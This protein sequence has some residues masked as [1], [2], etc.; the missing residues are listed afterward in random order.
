MGGILVL[1]SVRPL[2]VAGVPVL[3][4]AALCLVMVAVVLAAGCVGGDII[5]EQDLVVIKLNHNGTTAWMKT[6]DS[7]KD[8]EV[9]AVIQT[10]DGGY[11]IA[12]GYSTPL[13]NQWTHFPT[14]PKIIRLSGEGDIVW[15]REYSHESRQVHNVPNFMSGIIQSPDNGFFALSRYGTIMQI[16]SSGSIIQ[17]RLHNAGDINNTQI[18]STARTDDGGMAIAGFTMKCLSNKRPECAPDDTSYRAFVEKLDPVGNITWSHSYSEQGFIQA[19]SIIELI[20]DRSFLTTMLKQNSN[21]YSN[22]YVFLNSNG[23]VRNISSGSSIMPGYQIQ[24]IPE[25]FSVF[26]VNPNLNNTLIEYS[27]TNEGFLINTKNLMNISHH[28]T[29]PDQ[30][31][32]IITR[33][34]NY[35]ST[36]LVESG[37]GTK[38]PT[39]TVNLK[40]LNQDG[41][42]N[43][44]RKVSSFEKGKMYIHIRDIIETDDGGY[45]LIL[46]V[47]KTRA[48]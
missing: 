24:T 1:M 11:A 14:T 16:N 39:T 17:I 15:E 35:I 5:R 44:D 23:L 9:T 13:C 30:D 2:S 3:A 25:G 32:T 10:S 31:R 28:D 37:A 42:I 33:D 12:G 45:L 47:E 29:P 18:S 4:A 43:W 20:N 34:R 21:S 48:C 41:L 7:G 6:I 19:S 27:Y 26:S 36:N 22:S 40:E 8:D 38:S 46:G